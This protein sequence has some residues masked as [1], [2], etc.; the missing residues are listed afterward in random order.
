M[1]KSAKS[2]AAKSKAAKKPT[3]NIET[4]KF[5][6][7]KHDLAQALMDYLLKQK[8][9]EVLQLVDGLRNLKEIKVNTPQKEKK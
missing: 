7:L 2:K 8:C 5:Y 1:T 4:Q 3:E 9:G 6:L